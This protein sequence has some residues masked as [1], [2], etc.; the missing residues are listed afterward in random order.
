MRGGYF[1]GSGRVV[2]IAQ[3]ILGLLWESAAA[4][5]DRGCVEVGDLPRSVCVR[6]MAGRDGRATQ[7]ARVIVPGELA[8]SD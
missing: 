7:N 8:V 3:P 2:T 5:S 6:R 4:Y 1:Y